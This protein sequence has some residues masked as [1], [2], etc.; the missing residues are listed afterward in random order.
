[1]VLL[2]SLEF[3]L[4]ADRLNLAPFSFSPADP[5]AKEARPFWERFRASA[6]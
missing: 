1:M 3:D 2:L 5:I 4:V 6:E